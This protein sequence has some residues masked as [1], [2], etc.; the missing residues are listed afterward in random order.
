MEWTCMN[1]KNPKGRKIFNLW[2]EYGGSFPLSRDAKKLKIGVQWVP[3]L[4]AI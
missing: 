1:L 4:M 3:N 2:D